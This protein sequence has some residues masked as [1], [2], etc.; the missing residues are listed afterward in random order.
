MCITQPKGFNFFTVN[1]HMYLQFRGTGWHLAD[2]LAI[3]A[4]QLIRQGKI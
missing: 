4:I 1:M 3:A 2:N